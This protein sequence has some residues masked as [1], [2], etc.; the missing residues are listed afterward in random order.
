V[1]GGGRNASSWWKD[2]CVVREVVGLSVGRWFN[3]NISWRV[4]NDKQT[5]FRKHDWLDE[6]PQ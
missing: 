1:K 3:N 2:V 4:G 5:Y 6:G